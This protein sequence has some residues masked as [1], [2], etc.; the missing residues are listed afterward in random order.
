MSFKISIP[1]S[2]HQFTAEA[3]QTILTAAI[4]AG[5]NL[6]YGCRDG[7]CGSCKGQLLTGTVDQGHYN[8]NVLNGDEI[9]SGKTLFC[10]A[11]PLSDCMIA[12]REILDST[13]VKPRILPARVEKKVLLTPD[14]MAIYIKLPSNERLEFRAGQFVEFIMKNGL[15]RAYSIANAPHD[16]AVLEFHLHKIENG[17]FTSF[18]FDEMPEKAI[19]RLEAPFGSFYL[20]EDSDKPIIFVA[21]GTGFAPI[22][23]II[24]H[25]I[26]TKKSRKNSR[27]MVLYWGAKTEADLYMNDL[28]ACWAS[29]HDVQYIPVLSRANSLWTGRTGYP[30][31]AV[32]TDYADLSAF[33]VYACGAPK[34][35]DLA[36]QAFKTKGL[37]EDA[38][39]SDAFTAAVN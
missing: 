1:A 17:V 26:H 27:K 14:T 7:A 15:R 24:E 5:I 31:E 3:N 39:F 13:V 22:K 6:P 12:P 19:L 21:S 30:Q 18:I 4:N 10:C 16:D 9:A 29:E 11:I 33:E 23:G 35:V 20:R 2:G 32:M 28:A 37:A 34:M 38:F 36:L 8:F 25:A